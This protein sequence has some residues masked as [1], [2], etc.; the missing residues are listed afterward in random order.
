VLPPDAAKAAISYIGVN[1]G[2]F[3]VKVVVVRPDAA[4]AKVI[5]HQ[6]CTLEVL[7]VL[8]QSVGYPKE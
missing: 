5:T 3:T 1:I 7:Q 4:T 2:A 8:A 6:G